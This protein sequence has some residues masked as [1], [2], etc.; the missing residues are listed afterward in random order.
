M[1]IKVKVTEEIVKIKARGNAK[2]L[3]SMFAPTPKKR[4]PIRKVI[5]PKG[6]YDSIMAEIVD[7]EVEASTT[8]TTQK[9]GK[10]K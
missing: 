8:K 3:R 6:D 1:K 9:R 10:R 7:F 2:E 4:P 5:A